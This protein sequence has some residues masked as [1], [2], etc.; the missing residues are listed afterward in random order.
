MLP[1]IDKRGADPP[2]VDVGQ[3]CR[4][5]AE[6]DP[7]AGRGVGDAVDEAVRP[8]ALLAGVDDLDARQHEVGRPDH[9]D[10]VDTRADERGAEHEGD[11]DLD[12]RVVHRAARNCVALEDEPVV[13]QRAVVRF[14]GSGQ[15]A[16]RLRGQPDLVTLD[17]PPGRH[18]QLGDGHRD[19]VGVVDVG[20]G[21]RRRDRRD[22]FSGQLGVVQRL[23]GFVDLSF[24][25][26]PGTA[27]SR[28]QRVT[29]A[30][31]P[32]SV[33][34]YTVTGRSI[35]NGRNGGSSSAGEVLRVLRPRAP[36]S[37]AGRAGVGHRSR[38]RAA[39][40][41]DHL[42]VVGE[43]N[44]QPSHPAAG[45]GPTGSS[46]NRR[47]TARRR[48]TR[49]RPAGRAERHPVRRWRPSSSARPRVVPRRTPTAACRRSS[50]GRRTPRAA[51]V[52]LQARPQPSA[53]AE[54]AGA[55]LGGLRSVR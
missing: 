34:A 7:P 46:A 45:C 35:Q 20:V 49:R 31:N 15:R 4:A 6:H 16:H 54:V 2:D 17:D 10:G 33:Q 3:P 12:E 24:V 53:A 22:Q 5:S 44:R 41:D 38:T 36:A 9:V 37:T 23:G 26:D 25:Q 29:L 27:S 21:I 18:L 14:R 40:E 42:V 30:G 1:L 8:A 50:P 52:D 11:L 28:C 55:V 32:V 51:V 47:S 43:V 19:A 48:P 13:E 39:L